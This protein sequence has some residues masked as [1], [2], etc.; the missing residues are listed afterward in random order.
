MKAKENIVL[1]PRCRLVAVARR[2]TEKEHR[3]GN[4]MA[5]VDALSRQ[6]G[7]IVQGYT[8]DKEDVLREQAKTPLHEA[9]SSCL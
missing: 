1:A 5:H 9:E 3:A 7:T 4:K 8:L 2:K 6:V